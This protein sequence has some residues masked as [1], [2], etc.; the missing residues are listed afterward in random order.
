[1]FAMSLM[2]LV[3]QIFT[4]LGNMIPAIQ[5]A[6]SAACLFFF[7]QEFVCRRCVLHALC[8]HFTRSNKREQPKRHNVYIDAHR[9]Q[10]KCKT[11]LIQ[12]KPINST[13][14]TQ[15]FAAELRDITSPALHTPEY[16]IF[17]SCLH[18]PKTTAVPS[19]SA[20][21]QPS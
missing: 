3:L 7:C 16:D 13:S 9:P 4:L 10:K 15:L 8:T 2:L 12:N 6:T 14:A 20:A 5:A 18:S 19:L 11:S 17:S 21:V 1:M